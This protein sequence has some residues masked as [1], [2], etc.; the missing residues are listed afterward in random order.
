MKKKKTEKNSKMHEKQ[1]IWFI[2]DVWSANTR[3][4][5]TTELYERKCVDVLDQMVCDANDTQ[6][7]SNII[8]QFIA[9]KS[10]AIN[11]VCCCVYVVVIL[12][13]LFFHHF[14]FSF[15]I[16]ILTKNINT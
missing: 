11:I 16:C 3:T 5:S 2:C 6:N 7:Y 15:V 13:F 8:V 10:I 4:I 1:K 14:L 12:F 9:Y